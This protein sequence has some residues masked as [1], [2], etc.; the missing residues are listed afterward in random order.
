MPDVSK[1]TRVLV[2]D[3][4]NKFGLMIAAIL[5][6][7]FAREVVVVQTVDA[8][9]TEIGK[10]R[11]DVLITDLGFGPTLGGLELIRQVRAHKAFAVQTLPILVLSANADMATVRRAQAMGVNDF[12]GKPVSAALLLQRLHAMTRACANTVELPGDPVSVGF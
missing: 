10:Q 11:P 8:A 2:A 4:H 12:L 3:D 1:V 7:A 5:R 9:M 6:A